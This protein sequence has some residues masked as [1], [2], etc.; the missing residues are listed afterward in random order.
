MVFLFMSFN[1]R[2]SVEGLLRF[3][4]FRI[5]EQS[6][7]SAGEFKI[8]LIL[9]ILC[10]PSYFNVNMLVM[11]G[12]SCVVCPSTHRSWFGEDLVIKTQLLQTSVN[13]WPLT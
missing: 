9:S 8:T 10:R 1:R 12:H 11:K 6:K 13:G 3:V 5:L 2:N 7:F 4:V